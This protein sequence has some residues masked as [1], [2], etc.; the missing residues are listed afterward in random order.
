MGEEN[1]TAGSHG[2]GSSDIGDIMHIM[3][4]IHPYVAGAAGLAHTKN[5]EIID[6]ELFYVMPAKIMGMTIIDL[7]A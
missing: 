2:S 7:L 1:V 4:A 5:Y 3:P 6:Q